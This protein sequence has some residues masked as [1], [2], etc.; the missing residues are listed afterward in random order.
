M[1][2][3]SLEM[4][5]F[6]GREREEEGMGTE[7][8]RNG[9]V[10]ESFHL[11]F[12]LSESH[13]YEGG[14]GRKEGRMEGSNGRLQRRPHESDAHAA[15]LPLADKIGF[16]RLNREGTGRGRRTEGEERWPNMRRRLGMGIEWV[17]T[18]RS[19]HN[20]ENDIGRRTGALERHPNNWVCVDSPAQSRR[21]NANRAETVQI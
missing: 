14:E 20:A 10:L 19:R 12:A 9:G 6:G 5:L 3:I 8:G 4:A 16:S 21:P 13:G 2:D 15:C 1:A 17:A 18:A 7:E 11:R